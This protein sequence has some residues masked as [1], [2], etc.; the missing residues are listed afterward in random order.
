MATDITKT[1][2]P[3]CGCDVDC[4]RVTIIPLLHPGDRTTWL[5][6]CGEWCVATIEGDYTIKVERY[7]PWESLDHCS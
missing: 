3:H 6:E 4:S 5:C 7:D 1:K 2:C